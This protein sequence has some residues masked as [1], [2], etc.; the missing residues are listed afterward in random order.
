M[1]QPHFYN[2][3]FPFSKISPHSKKVTTITSC[4]PFE[5]KWIVLRSQLYS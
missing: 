3:I 5:T 4:M 1:I 2:F